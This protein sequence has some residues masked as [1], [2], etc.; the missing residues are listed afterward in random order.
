MNNLPRRTVLLYL[1]AIFS[2]GAAGGLAL[3]YA[4]GRKKTL[5]PPPPSEMATVIRSHLESR[6]ALSPEQ[7]ARIQPVVEQSCAEIESV[8]RECRDQISARFQ[9]MHQRIA[10]YLTP[11]QRLKLAELEKEWRDRTCGPHKTLPPRREERP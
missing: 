9:L 4:S 8:Q 1:L 2:A 5:H 7:A 10:D 3:G 6:L 11:A